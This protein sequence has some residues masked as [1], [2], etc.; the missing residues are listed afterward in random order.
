MVLGLQD[1][2]D[3][4]V[5][6][7]TRQVKLDWKRLKRREHMARLRTHRK[8][9]LQSMQS[10][11]AQLELQYRQ[12]LALLNRK[13]NDSEKSHSMYQ[14]VLESDAFRAENVELRLKLQQHSRLH[15]LILENLV[16]SQPEYHDSSKESLYEASAKSPW[17][18]H[19][20]SLDSGWR[21]NFQHG[22]PS[23]FFHP[24]TREEFDSSIKQ[25]LSTFGASPPNIKQVGVIFGW[26]VHCAPPTR[27]EGKSLVSHARFTTRFASSFDETNKTIAFTE[28][29]LLPLIST[30]P[31]WSSLQRDRVSTQLLQEF[32]KNAYVM[33]CNIPGPVHMRYLYL[34]RR[35]PCTVS[36]GKRR[37]SF[38]QVIATTK[39]NERSRSAEALYNE[40]EWVQ[41]GGTFT[42]LTEV[43]ERTVDV[44]YDQ[45]ASCHDDHHAQSLFIQWA[46][47]VSRL[48]QTIEASRLL[49]PGE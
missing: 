1:W 6:E 4:T 30:P 24:F 19:P 7:W 34:L 35:L 46:Q 32:E 12:H 28:L 36:N 33:A 38:V 20:H 43:D 23:F 27:R 13:S 45:W 47:F 48:S 15:S 42:T 18:S 44:S 9:E 39:A 17:K 40:V 5:Q 2:A 31:R 41:E 11:R 26:N 21:V 29:A 10:E 22:R 49:V 3:S 8:S 25:A 37:V 14:L 16:V